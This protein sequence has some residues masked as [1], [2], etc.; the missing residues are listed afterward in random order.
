MIGSAVAKRYATAL[1]ELAVE[2][3]VADKIGSDLAD[4]AKS[5]E[6]SPELQNVVQNP[7]FG[8]EAKRQVIAAVADRAGVHAIVKNTLLMLS[9]R[10]RLSHLPEIAEVY[11]R[12]AERRSGKVRAEI[13]TATKLPEAYYTQL[14]NTLKQAT[15]KDVL[16]VRREDPSLIGGVITTIG[17]RVFDGSIKNR[18]RQLRSNLLAS[19]DPATLAN[20]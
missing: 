18:L 15:G 12:L 10:R 1:Y 20:D 8:M 6:E 9:D 3:N 2:K 5:W 14:Q 13:V 19:T 11:T 4:V 7:Q 16:L 17:G